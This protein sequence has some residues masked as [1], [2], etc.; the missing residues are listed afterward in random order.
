[1]FL[2]IGDT[3]NPPDFRPYVNYG[4]IGLNVAVFLLVSLPLITEAASL[5]DPGF[6]AYAEAL[7]QPPRT[8]YDVFVFLHGFKPGAFAVD[9]LFTSMFLHGDFAHLA[10]NMLF[11]WIYGDNVEHYLGRVA[12]L[13]TYLLTGVLATLAFAVFSQGSLVPLV[14]ASGAISGVLGLYFVLFP[15]NRIKLFIFLF[16]FIFQVFLVP[17]RVVLA[18]YLVVQNFVPALITNSPG[19]GVAYGAH[20]GGFLAGL[21]L[22]MLVVWLGL[23]A[24]RGAARKNRTAPPFRRPESPTTLAGQDVLEA[25]RDAVEDGRRADAVAGALNLGPRRLRHLQLWEILTLAEWMSSLDQRAA[26]TALARQALADHQTD[27]SARAQIHL[28]LGRMRLEEGQT[29]SAYQHLLTA[30]DLAPSS[31]TAREAKALLD[32]I[33]MY[34]RPN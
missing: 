23:S 3:P 20:I 30:I 13:V 12:Y 5:T 4:L 8:A 25:V 10:G 2:P 26:A 18:F 9:D 15:R 7:G 31:R 34:R 27:S 1:V 28:V 22:A 32:G 24:R 19:G 29:T 17:A 6:R 14:G 21:L 33:P 16:P 11:L